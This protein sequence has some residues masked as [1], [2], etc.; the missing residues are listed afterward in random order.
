MNFTDFVVRYC[1]DSIIENNNMYVLT[2]PK[3]SSTPRIYPLAAA[4]DSSRM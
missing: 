1:N 3:M 4:A 2:T